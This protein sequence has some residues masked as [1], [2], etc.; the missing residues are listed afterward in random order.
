MAGAVLIEAHG[1]WQVS[2]RRYLSEGSVALLTA[3]TRGVRS[4]QLVP[5]WTPRR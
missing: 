3:S 5:T 1:E 2:D 4:A